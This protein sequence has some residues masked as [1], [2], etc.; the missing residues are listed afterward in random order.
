[1]IVELTIDCYTG[2]YWEEDCIKVIEFDTNSTLEFLS[3]SILEL[4]KFDHDHLAIFF[5]GREASY[6]SAKIEFCEED[7]F[8]LTLDDIFPLPKG[9]QLFY[10]YDFGDNWIFQ[11]KKSRK[12]P[13]LPIVG[14]SYPRVIKEIG[15]NPNQYGPCD[16]E[17]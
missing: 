5:A 2:A 13:T 7:G 16:D 8:E 4:I 9:L 17:Y 6:R 10:Y 14:V 1:M 12:K 3:Y 15:P 11:I